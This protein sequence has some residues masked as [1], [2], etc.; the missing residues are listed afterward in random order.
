MKKATKLKLISG[1]IGIIFGLLIAE[2]GLRVYKFVIFQNLD[3][4]EF[5]DRDSI[6][7]PEDNLT[8]GHV[9]QISTFQKIIYELIP[10]SIYKFKDKIAETNDNGFRDKNYPT[11]KA[12][13]TK[14]I[15]GL[16]DSGMFG[17]GVGQEESYLS[18]LEAQLN[19]SD[20]IN[21]EV[22]NTGVP[23]Y[24]TVME[25]SVLENKIQMDQVDL[26]II[27]FVHN[28]FE[29]PSFIRKKPNFWTLKKSYILLFIEENFI[30]KHQ[31]QD[32]WLNLA[33]KDEKGLFESD[34]DKLPEEY[35]DMVGE[36]SFAEAMRRLKELSEEYGFEILVL[37]K[38]RSPKKP[39]IVTETCKELKIEIIEAG[40]A[41]RAYKET[42]PEG[43]WK[44]AERDWHP[45]AEAHHTIATALF[46]QIKEMEL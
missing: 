35:K 11:I 24:N 45:S 2:I 1:I 3:Q 44:L 16:G 30:A 46:D 20:S 7:Q 27:D 36:K 26:V 21:Y 18:K 15:I 43:E 8:L 38:E 42:H 41:W 14:R 40:P 31:K 28:D 13:N 9:I 32:K 25:V 10:N 19:Q 34:P 29:L 33:P 22:I 12:A 37:H 17:W 39:K 4:I 23:G 5:G 6:S